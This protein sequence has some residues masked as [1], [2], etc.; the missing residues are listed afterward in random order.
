MIKLFL[1]IS[2]IGLS[3]Y[4]TPSNCAEPF[5]VNITNQLTVPK[6]LFL[7]CASGDNKLGNQT[8]THGHSYSFHFHMNFFSTTKFW[9]YMEPDKYHYANFNVF[10]YDSKI[11]ERC[12]SFQNCY[13]TAR[14]AGVDI[15]DLKGN[16]VLPGPSLTPRLPSIIDVGYGFIKVHT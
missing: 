7:H 10:W 8:L 6:S 3:F 1:F 14:D 5:R 2:A 4:V 9:C 13:W 15:T 11:H 12:D 16:F